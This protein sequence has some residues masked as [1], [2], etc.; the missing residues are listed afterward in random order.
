MNRSLGALSRTDG[1]NQKTIAEW[2]KRKSTVDLA[3]EPKDPESSSLTIE[4]EAVVVAFRRHA[5]L[6][7]DGYQYALQR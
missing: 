1:V 4:E 6:H 2:T 3:T 5:L 7:L